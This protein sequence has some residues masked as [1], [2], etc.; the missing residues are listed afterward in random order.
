MHT[1]MKKSNQHQHILIDAAGDVQSKLASYL[2]GDKSHSIFVY[3]S[4]KN[5]G[6]QLF[7]SQQ[8]WNFRNEGFC[9]KY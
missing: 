9:V 6:S 2:N 8:Q 3:V 4:F 7:N 5:N 1:G